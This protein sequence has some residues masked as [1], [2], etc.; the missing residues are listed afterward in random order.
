MA[1][2]VNSSGLLKLRNRLASRW[3]PWLTAQDKQGYRPHITIQ[4]KVDPLEARRLFEFMVETWQPVAGT[5]AGVQLWHYR[6]GPWD[7]AREFLFKQQD[8]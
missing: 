6:G 8:A 5:A 3:G 2:E 1:I 4:N 7:L